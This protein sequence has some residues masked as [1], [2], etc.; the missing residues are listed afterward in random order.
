LGATG[1]RGLDVSSGVE[2]G[3]GVKDPRK[4]ARFVAQARRAAV[5][6]GSERAI[7]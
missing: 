1:A 3:P 4:I 2:T 5:A 6:L 7:G